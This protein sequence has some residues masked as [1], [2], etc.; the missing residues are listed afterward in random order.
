VNP[1]EGDLVGLVPAAGRALRLAGALGVT[2]AGTSKEVLP[3]GGPGG[4]SGKPR[5]AAAHLLSAFARAG[6]DRAY[7]VL[8]EGKWDVPEALT[9]ALAESA[10]EAL[11]L[12]YLVLRESSSVAETL[13]AAYPFVRGRRVALGFPDILFRPADAFLRVRER[14][15]A[16]GADAVLGLVPTD[17]PEKADV[18][19]ADADGRVREIVIKP[20]MQPARP[21]GV[22]AFTAFTWIAAVWGPAITERLH[23]EVAAVR[24]AAAEGTVPE[25]ELYPGDV[26]ARAAADGLRIEAVTFPEGTHLDIGT[27]DDLVR[28]RDWR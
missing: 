12:A 16:T 19:V 2:A 25:R 24:R 11:R 4:P 10:P 1:T 17:R 15:E 6:V 27:P 18:V 5:P 21:E 8:R 14:Q 22:P 7:V 3:V 20:P 23:D 26:L 28:A 13:D 9:R